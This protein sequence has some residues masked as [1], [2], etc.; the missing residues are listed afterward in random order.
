MAKAQL[1]KSSD[2][3]RKKPSSSSSTDPSGP[4]PLLNGHLLKVKVLR[5]CRPILLKD[6]DPVDILD[7]L[8]IDD[9]LKTDLRDYVL[10]PKTREERVLA[11]LDRLEKSDEVIFFVF[12]DALRDRYRH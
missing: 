11:L 4:R 9:S 10:T 12:V 1:H 2:V 7:R 8:T 6:L 5:R 3:F